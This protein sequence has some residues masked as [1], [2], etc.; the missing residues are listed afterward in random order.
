M[1][2]LPDQTLRNE[3]H[4]SANAIKGT[5]PVADIPWISSGMFP[6]ALRVENKA[7]ELHRATILGELALKTIL[8]DS[9]CYL[10]AAHMHVHL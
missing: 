10:S 2:H 7:D 1:E 8:E 6:N 9:L 5:S 4:A 3:E